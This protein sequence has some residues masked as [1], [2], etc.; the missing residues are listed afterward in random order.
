L[1]HGHFDSGP[2]Y[3]LASVQERLE[4]DRPAAP[5]HQS[6]VDQHMAR[7]ES[8]R[9]AQDLHNAHTHKNRLS[10]ENVDGAIVGAMM[11]PLLAK[12]SPKIFAD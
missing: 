5:S 10:D 8:P 2:G 6:P 9:L 1:R 4:A 11:V 3:A 7:C 12:L